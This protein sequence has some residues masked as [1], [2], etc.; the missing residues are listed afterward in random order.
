[1]PSRFDFLEIE[2][3][4]RRQPRPSWAGGRAAVRVRPAEG[5][6]LKPLEIIGER[7]SQPGQFQS[8]M[9]L[10][11]DREGS[12]Y[13]A[14]SYNHRIQRFSPDGS[15]AILGEPGSQRGQ[16]LFPVGV[17]VDA[18]LC[19]YVLEQANHRLQKLSAGG[20]S[21]WIVGGR[22]ISL[23]QF[24][25]P[26]AVC[27][28]KFHNLY[29]AD[30]G[31]SRIQSFTAAGG[32]RFAISNGDLGL[33]MPRGVAADVLCSMYVAD[34]LN[35]RIVRI[36]ADCR[37]AVSFGRPGLARGSF[38]EP[39]AIAVDCR[40]IVYVGEACARRIQCFTQSG[41][42]LHVFTAQ[43]RLAL[44]QTGGVRVGLVAPGGIACDGDGTL[45]V[46]DTL[47]HRVVRM[48]IVTQ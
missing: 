21:L 35:D 40:G 10:A 39:E 28:D 17:C 22:G 34:T 20:T 6:R 43:R 15:V 16:F 14:D 1:M 33:H 26:A 38:R 36:S 47:G 27:I 48:A 29:I 25:A 23:C 4:V 7:G 30:S 8:P 46:S 2:G 12:L 45:Y 9:G 37:E 24:V 18:S 32:F 19:I 44:P 5:F 41:K 13:V 3:A 31:N 42:L 11:V